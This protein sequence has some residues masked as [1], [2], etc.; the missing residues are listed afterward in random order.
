MYFLLFLLLF[1]VRSAFTITANDA[2]AVPIHAKR[3]ILSPVFALEE[4]LVEAVVLSDTEPLPC[5]VKSVGLSIGVT[6]ESL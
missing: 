5:V 3:F 6:E 2:T 4:A 1:L